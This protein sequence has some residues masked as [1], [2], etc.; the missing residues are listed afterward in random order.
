MDSPK[1]NATDVPARPGQENSSNR[2][3]GYGSTVGTPEKRGSQLTSPDRIEGSQVCRK[4]PIPFQL[5]GPANLGRFEKDV[6][7]ATIDR[8]K[9]VL[10]LI[11]G[12]LLGYMQRSRLRYRPMAIRLMVLGK[13]E[14][15]AIPWIVVLCNEDQSKRVKRFFEKKLAK[16]LCRPQDLTLPPFDVLIVNQPLRTKTRTEVYGGVFSQNVDF[17]TRTSC[18]TI[19]KLVTAEQTRFATL[20]GIIKVMSSS[21]DYALFGMTAGHIAEELETLDDCEGESERDEN[22]HEE[23]SSDDES[24]ADATEN[25]DI[26]FN[27]HDALHRVLSPV[28]ASPSPKPSL[29]V[30]DTWV[31]LGN[32]LLKTWDSK[33]QRNYD[34]ALIENLDQRYYRQNRFT[35]RVPRYR[36]E[37][38]EPSE[39]RVNFQKAQSVIMISGS[40]V[41]KR[42][43][44]SSLPS[45]VLLAPGQKFIQTYTLALDDGSG[46]IKS[47]L[48][49]GSN[50]LT[51]K[52]YQKY[53]KAIQVLGLLTKQLSRST[54]MS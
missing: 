5:A 48:L 41:L 37:L 43:K 16:D 21:G 52:I 28:E 2:D 45:M 40:Q 18:G 9:D 10:E 25:S 26:F 44:L 49:R 19:I 35:G 30:P 39:S 50:L 20:G 6:D 29:E 7:K 11:E 14:E 27:T 54:G 51:F 38:K 17:P 24:E 15:D 3:S 23:V 47:H 1:P 31:K 32:T 53:A 8:F 42:G 46:T 22:Q 36:Q 12:P 34:W 4:L 33:H 13:S